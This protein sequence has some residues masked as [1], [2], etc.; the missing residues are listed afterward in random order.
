MNTSIEAA[1]AFR[2]IL[3]SEIEQAQRLLD[4]LRAENS[5]LQKGSPQAL[6]ELL[7][8]KTQQL[9]LVESA[10]AAHNRF[11]EQQGMSV[12]RQG[13]ENLIRQSGDGETLDRIWQR[14]SKLLED[15]HKQNEINGGAIKLN[16][17]HVT[18]AI[19]ILRGLGQRDKTYGPSGETKP[20]ST[21]K[22][23][24]KA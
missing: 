10:V 13:T 23:L 21:S 20:N 6:Q 24:G 17:R 16:Q 8:E 14:F 2:G 12:D 19:D 15:C 22:S 4:L 1:S 11:L 3:E 18:Q 7:V 9:K 5:L